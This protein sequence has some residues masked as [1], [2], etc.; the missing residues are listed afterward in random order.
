MMT[1]TNLTTRGRASSL[2]SS[3]TLS[4]RRL[5]RRASSSVSSV[6][7]PSPPCRP[8]GEKKQSFQFKRKTLTDEQNELDDLGFN[9]ILIRDF[10]LR[11][12]IS[13]AISRSR[14]GIAREFHGVFVWLAGSVERLDRSRDGE[15]VVSRNGTFTV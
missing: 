15:R 3:C 8:F 10:V 6:S 7:S 1:S 14:G 5:R 2:P 11:R 13:F 9:V 12:D 4:R